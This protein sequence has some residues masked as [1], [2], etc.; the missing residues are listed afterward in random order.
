[1][2]NFVKLV[3]SAFVPLRPASS[4]VPQESPHDTKLC[5][6]VWEK[7]K[8]CTK[9]H[10]FLT[11]CDSDNIRI[12]NII[13]QPVFNFPH[14]KRILI[15]QIMYKPVPIFCSLLESI[16]D[17]S[18]SHACSSGLVPLLLCL[19]LGKE[20]PRVPSGEFTMPHYQGPH[21]LYGYHAYKE[22]V[23]DIMDIQRLIP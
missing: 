22:S 10:H 13:M 12:I 6:E 2:A 19:E 1:M 23:P 15:F 7:S 17:V 5:R 16:P 20:L 3:L 18:S 8:V 4:L 21:T 11:N 14:K 9:G